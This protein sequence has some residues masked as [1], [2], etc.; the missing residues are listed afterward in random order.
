MITKIK[1]KAISNKMLP[2]VGMELG[3]SGG[4]SLVGIC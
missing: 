4:F 3:T 2:P 1:K